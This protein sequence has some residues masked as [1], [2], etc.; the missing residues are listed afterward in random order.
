MKDD[1]VRLYKFSD[2]TLIDEANA[3][4]VFMTRDAADFAGYG[5]DAAAL[6][7]FTALIDAFELFPPDHVYEAEVT[8][9]TQT[10]DGLRDEM[11]TM[12][13]AVLTRARVTWGADS[14]KYKEMNEPSISQMTDKEFLVTCRSIAAR[15]EEYLTE[16][17]AAG[18]TQLMIDDLKAKYAAFELA[19]AEK[20]EKIAN[21]DDKSVERVKK[22]NEIYEL[23]VKYCDIGKT[24][25]Y[26]T[27]E[28]RYNDYIIYPNHPEL[29]YKV[30]NL[31]Y[32]IPSGALTW[33]ASQN[34]ETYEMQF[35]PDIPGDPPW[36][37]EYEGPGTSFTFDPGGPDGYKFRVRGKNSFGSGEWS[38]VLIVDRS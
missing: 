10:K 35:A 2:A 23:M 29:P 19:L 34:S 22:G 30:Q 7:A 37:T 6:A 27:N 32:N 8:T 14:G 16:L 33:S 26:E 3:K 4:H 12:A 36:I 1:P 38:E 9:I 31:S 18:L 17:T 13:K 5:V 20:R 25:F 11:N 15:A 28:A 24:L 21:R